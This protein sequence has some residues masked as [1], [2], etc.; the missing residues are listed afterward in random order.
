MSQ[1]AS[2]PRGRPRGFWVGNTGLK[3]P[4]EATAA[5][6]H[7]MVGCRGRPLCPNSQGF[8]DEEVTTLVPL[9]VSMG[10]ELRRGERRPLEKQGTAVGP[11]EGSNRSCGPGGMAVAGAGHTSFP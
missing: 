11:V 5:T 3:R 4:G 1:G 8:G 6:H 7:C 2:G 9:G 10:A